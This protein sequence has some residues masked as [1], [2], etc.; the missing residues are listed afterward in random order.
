MSDILS[1]EFRE[2]LARVDNLL[3]AYRALKR[4]S[5]CEKQTRMDV[6]RAAVVMMHSSLEEIIRNMF[7]IRLPGGSVEALNKIPFVGHEATHRPKQI[8]LGDLSRFRGRFIDNIVRDSIDAYV[9]TMN[10]NN[11][12]QLC[13]CLEMVSL[14][15]EPF[16][17]TFQDL[18]AMMKRRHQIAH[19]MDRASDLN[20]TADPIEKINLRIVLAW[21]A[22][23]QSF[24]RLLLDALAQ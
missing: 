11:A 9:N 10:L 19:Q 13:N 3:N 20:L 15:P 2:N 4:H 21:R 1:V 16:R 8:L 14:S 22:A 7:L 17:N 24:H 18:D 6:L 23:L 12:V 5:L